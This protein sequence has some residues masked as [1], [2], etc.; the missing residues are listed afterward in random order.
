MSSAFEVGNAEMANRSKWQELPDPECRRRLEA[1]KAE[2]IRLSECVELWMPAMDK[3][4]DTM[5]VVPVEIRKELR[6]IPTPV[7][8]A[9]VRT[10]KEKLRD[11]SE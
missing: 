5:Y 4:T 7:P 2:L 6:G 3:I 10:A 11:I 9:K 8:E 1:M